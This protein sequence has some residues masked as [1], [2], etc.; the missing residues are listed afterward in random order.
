M[1]YVAFNELLWSCYTKFVFT[2]AVLLFNSFDEGI[3]NDTKEQIASILHYK[4][5]QIILISRPYQ[6][7]EG[8]SVERILKLELYSDCRMPE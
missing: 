3:P 7:Q 4:A 6:T 5:P 8:S 1:I 2:V